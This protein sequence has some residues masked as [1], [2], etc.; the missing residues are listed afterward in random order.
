MSHHALQLANGN[1]G[2][3]LCG[4]NA[5]CRLDRTISQLDDAYWT[6]ED[7]HGQAMTLRIR[8]DRTVQWVPVRVGAP[9]SLSL[10]SRGSECQMEIDAVSGFRLESRRRKG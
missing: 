1:K 6:L 10:T 2:I 9:I 3:L 8:V 4:D 5:R 7:M